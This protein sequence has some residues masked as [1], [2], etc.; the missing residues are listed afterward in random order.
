VKEKTNAPALTASDD[1]MELLIDGGAAVNLMP[2]S[3]FKKL[4]RED[5][6]LVKTNL[7]LNNVGGNPMEARGVMSIELTVGSKS[8]TTTFFIIEV[9]CNYS[10]I[11]GCDWIHA[12]HCLPSTLHQFFIQWINDEIKV[13]H[14][15][16]LTLL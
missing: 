16:R 6:E 14:T 10:I 9:P 1:D 12:N 4:G 2:H 5:E 15:R 3:L 8:L 13:V 11:L 7:T